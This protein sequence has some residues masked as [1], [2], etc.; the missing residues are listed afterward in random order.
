[1]CPC[2]GLHG[3]RPQSAAMTWATA[4]GGSL[5]RYTGYGL[6]SEKESPART[7][8]GKTPRTYP[9]LTNTESGITRRLNR[10][11]AKTI[12]ALQSPARVTRAG[13][14]AGIT[15]TTPPGR[16]LITPDPQ[17]RITKT[18]AAAANTAAA[19]YITDFRF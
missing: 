15:T 19:I 5:F 11:T 12:I 4:A 17:T 1:M 10:F 14:Q 2:F 9:C 3:R 13:I 8:T 6:F 7:N 16:A 18:K